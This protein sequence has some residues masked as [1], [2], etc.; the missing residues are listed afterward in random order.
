MILMDEHRLVRITKGR[1]RFKVV[2][3]SKHLSKHFITHTYLEDKPE[4]CICIDFKIVVY[5]LNQYK[6]RL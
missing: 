5:S 3:C 6:L 1:D 2:K 4:H